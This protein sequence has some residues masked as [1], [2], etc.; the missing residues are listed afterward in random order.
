MELVWTRHL[1]STSANFALVVGVPPKI[2]GRG[3]PLLISST[4]GLT[5][6]ELFH[7]P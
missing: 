2:L 7:F 5:V 4:T 3:E 6:M 1:T